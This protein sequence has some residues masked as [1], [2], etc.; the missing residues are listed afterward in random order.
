M[1]DPES[2]SPCELLMLPR[3]WPIRWCLLHPR[4]IPGISECSMERV[5]LFIRWCEYA[6][7]ENVLH[8]GTHLTLCRKA[9][10]G[11]RTIRRYWRYACSIH[12][13]TNLKRS[14]RRGV[15]RYTANPNTVYADGNVR[16]E[17]SESEVRLRWRNRWW[18]IRVNNQKYL[19]LR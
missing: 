19:F 12:S 18:R 17:W 1:Q 4:T 6:N 3:W 16:I 7:S 9:H 2:V 14:A 11:M 13:G 5:S 8:Q 15:Q 10:C